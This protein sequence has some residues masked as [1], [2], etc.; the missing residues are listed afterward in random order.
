MLVG[1]DRKRLEPPLVQMPVTDVRLGTL[2]A[3]RMHVGHA[4]HEGRQ[5]AVASWPEDEVPMIGHPTVRGDA[6]WGDAE[7]LFDDTLEG[8]IV[9]LVLEDPHSANTPVEYVE[10]HSSG[11][12]SGGSRHEARL[13]R[14]ARTVNICACPLFPFRCGLGSLRR[15]FL[16]VPFY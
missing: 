13:P 2:P 11:R 3:L 15:L 7:R 5:I 8:G 14:P 9:V 12:D 4:L 10:N 1:L 6:D 16:R